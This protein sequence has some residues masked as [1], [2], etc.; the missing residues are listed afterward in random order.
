MIK[1]IVQFLQEMV[2]LIR[3]QGRE[4]ENK[5]GVMVVKS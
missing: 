3:K 2:F 5:P 1:W 4:K